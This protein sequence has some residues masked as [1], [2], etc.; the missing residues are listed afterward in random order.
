MAAEAKVWPD[1]SACADVGR[2]VVEEG[3]IS[4]LGWALRDGVEVVVLGAVLWEVAV[5]CAGM[6]L[7]MAL[8]LELLPGLVVG[9]GL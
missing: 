7:A 6:E 2:V 4:G 8:A 3:G 1:S 9:L 5:W